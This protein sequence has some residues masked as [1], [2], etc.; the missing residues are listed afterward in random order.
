MAIEELKRSRLN[1]L[2]VEDVLKALE[3]WQEMQDDPLVKS[4]H[5][6]DKACEHLRR[7]RE[8]LDLDR[9]SL[10]DESIHRL[11]R[12]LADLHTLMIGK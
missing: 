12:A 4:S 6:F 1:E 2:K 3:V 9:E 10:H 11:R 7:A 5:E 8:F